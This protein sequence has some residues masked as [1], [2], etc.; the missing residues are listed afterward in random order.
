[1][2]TTLIGA[3]FALLS[4]A[5]PPGA[6][7]ILIPIE[8]TGLSAS[9]LEILTFLKLTLL[10]QILWRK[11]PLGADWKGW[12]TL[13]DRSVGM[14]GSSSTNAPCSTSHDGRTKQ[15]PVSIADSIATNGLSQARE[16]AH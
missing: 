11:L 10:V 7:Q 9:F 6:R 8:M 2:S 3:L 12:P 1:M 14:S 4:A 13:P 15:C 16:D 5:F